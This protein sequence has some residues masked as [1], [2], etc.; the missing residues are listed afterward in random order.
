MTMVNTIGYYEGRNAGNQGRGAGRRLPG[1]PGGTPP[2]PA[3]GAFCAG[4]ST[5]PPAHAADGPGAGA[6][7][8][9]TRRP[10][11]EGRGQGAAL[12]PLGGCVTLARDLVQVPR[13]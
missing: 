8:P 13:S 10:G 11:A 2:S 5:R 12:A 1:P 4:P 6:A 7:A 9:G 3:A